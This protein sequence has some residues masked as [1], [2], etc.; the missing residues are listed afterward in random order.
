MLFLPDLFDAWYRGCGSRDRVGASSEWTGM[1][2]LFLGTRKFLV[3]YS[4]NAY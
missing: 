3:I 2:L 4:T 1:E